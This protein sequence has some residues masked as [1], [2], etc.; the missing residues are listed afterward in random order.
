[1]LAPF[2]TGSISGLVG[3]ILWDRRTVILIGAKER[4]LCMKDC[5]TERRLGL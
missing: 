3:S 5:H 1:M 4:K 2:L